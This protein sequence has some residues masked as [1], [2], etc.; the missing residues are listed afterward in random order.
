M[1]YRLE[2]VALALLANCAPES[3]P[4][5]VSQFIAACWPGMSRAQLLSLARRFAMRASLR[6]RPERGP[7]GVQF[8]ALVLVIGQERTELIAHV[9][10][11]AR[12]CGSRRDRVSSPPARDTRQQGL[13]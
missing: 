10:R 12:R 6:A 4:T 1:A 11:L 8:Y 3:L 2:L 9:R 13:F 5:P 7:A